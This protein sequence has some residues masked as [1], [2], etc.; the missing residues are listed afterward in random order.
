M[1]GNDSV[2]DDWLVILHGPKAQTGQESNGLILIF[3]V[4]N[5]VPR[6]EA[7]SL[8]QKHLGRWWEIG[9]CVTQAG[10]NL[11]IY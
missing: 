9:S 5:T 3:S 8:N 2:I 6:R 7:V 10:L 4:S 1:I 11:T